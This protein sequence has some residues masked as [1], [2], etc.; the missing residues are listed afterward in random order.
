MNLM[1]AAHGKLLRRLNGK[2]LGDRDRADD[3]QPLDDGELQTI[4]ILLANVYPHIGNLVAL[5]HAEEK[6]HPDRVPL[7]R[8]LIR[9]LSTGEPVTQ[10]MRSPAPKLVRLLA[11]NQMTYP[12]ARAALSM[13]SPLLCDLWEVFGNNAHFAEAMVW[14]A[15]QAERVEASLESPEH[16]R[17]CCRAPSGPE[18][19]FRQAGAFYSATVKRQ[20]P[21]Y[22]NLES[23]KKKQDKQD[24]D[25][26]DS[27]TADC[28][29]YYDTFRAYTGGFMILWCRCVAL[30]PFVAP[31]NSDLQAPCMCRLPHN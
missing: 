27:A 28:R 31:V 14:V 16:L 30:V 7:L 5:C 3:L 12:N 11:Q 10:F 8:R 23:D 29:K 25:A 15:E 6:E 24:E 1:K 21:F 26:T 22:V 9:V 2:V 4:S 18:P 20:R 19:D 17:T 13:F